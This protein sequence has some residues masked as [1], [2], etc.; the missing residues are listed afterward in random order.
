M[1]LKPPQPLYKRFGCA[2]AYILVASLVGL[3]LIGMLG[4]QPMTL[5]WL[6]AQTLCLLIAIGCFIFLIVAF[7]F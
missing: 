4:P 7:N 3:I 5:G 6:V 2:A 1:L